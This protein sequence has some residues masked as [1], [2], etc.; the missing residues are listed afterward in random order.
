MGVPF[1]LK[2][3]GDIEVLGNGEGWG[4][5]E[6]E[7]F[8]DLLGFRKNSMFGEGGFIQTVLFENI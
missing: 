5:K 3:Y 8:R 1:Y 7:H 2:W 4:P 6:I